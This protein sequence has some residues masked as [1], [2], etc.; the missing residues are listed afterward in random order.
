LLNREEQV[1][2]L[3]PRAVSEVIFF[4]IPFH[5]CDEGNGINWRSVAGKVEI[6]RDGLGR[7]FGDS[8]DRRRRSGTAR[9]F[10]TSGGSAGQRDGYQ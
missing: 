1:A 10:T 2:L 4:E 5:S 7:G 8:D 9:V 3:D 6:V